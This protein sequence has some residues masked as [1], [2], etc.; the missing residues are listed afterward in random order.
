MVK[1]Q[2]RDCTTEDAQRAVRAI[3]LAH[4]QQLVTLELI[5]AP[6]NLVSVASVVIGV[7][8]ATGVYTESVRLTT[9]ETLGV[10]HVTAINWDLTVTTVTR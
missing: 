4:F 9:R 3:L 8:L 1:P 7:T 2:P 10:Y 5:N 6:V